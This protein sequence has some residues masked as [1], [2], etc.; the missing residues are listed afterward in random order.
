EGD[1]EAASLEPARGAAGEEGEIGAMPE[2]G[3]EAEQSANDDGRIRRGAR[4]GVESEGP[5]EPEVRFGGGLRGRSG[6]ERG[7]PPGNGASAGEG[8]GRDI[9]ARVRGEGERGGRGCGGEG[10]PRRAH[11]VRR[12]T[13]RVW[14]AGEARC[15]AARRS[16]AGASW[17]SAGGVFGRIR[18]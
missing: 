11:G 10:D 5:L 9:G 3:H 13:E 15:H 4:A 6:V 7:L 12:S 14:G 2:E 18:P 1:A 16:R 8:P 17:P